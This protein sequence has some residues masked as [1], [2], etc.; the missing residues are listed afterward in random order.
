MNTQGNYY[1]IQALRA[2]AA[3][4]VVFHHIGIDLFHNQR[5]VPAFLFPFTAFGSI[6]VDIFFVVSGFVISFCVGNYKGKPLNFWMNR[7]IRIFP[8]YWFYTIVMSF[9]ILYLPSWVFHT[10]GISLENFLLSLILVPHENIGG[11][12]NLP[13]LEVGWTLTFEMIFYTI[14]SVSLL[15]DKRLYTTICVAALVLVMALG[16]VFAM[17]KALGGDIFLFFEF[18]FG[19]FIFKFINTEFKYKRLIVPIV[20]G[21]SLTTAITIFYFKGNSGLSK[22]VLSGP[23][24]LALVSIEFVFR[25][26]IRLSKCFKHFGDVS[27]S[28][29]LCHMIWIG[30]FSYTYNIFSSSTIFIFSIIFS[31]YVSSVL[32]Y[33]F[34]ERGKFN[35]WI[36]GCFQKL[37]KNIYIN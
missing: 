36:R 17:D 22:L 11:Y 14:F 30:I 1:S 23:I 27:Y 13:V 20:V 4:I 16:K 7:I 31:T 24:V 2:I 15:F 25:K 9:L 26:F 29:Y 6:G 28:T 18:I 32:S 5:E 19:I 35:N 33:N 3:W 10:T 34:I 8:N 21:I 37:Q 12:G